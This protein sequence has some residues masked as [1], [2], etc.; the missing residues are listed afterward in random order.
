MLGRLKSW[1]MDGLF[2]F[3]GGVDEPFYTPLNAL[4]NVY[5]RLKNPERIQHLGDLHP[6]KIFYIIRDVPACTGLASWYD[7]VLGYML[8]AKRKGWV[9]VVD[10]PAPAK[11]DDG[12][13]YDFFKGPSDIPVEEALQ[14]SNVVFATEQAMVYKRFSKSN[15]ARRHL[16]A[17]AIQF[18]EEA[19]AFVDAHVSE[20]F[21]AMPRPT[22]G[23]VFRGTDYRSTADYRPT[24]HAKVPSLDFFCDEVLS[25]LKRWGVPEDGGANL[26]VVTE[27]QEAL[28]IIK[29]RFPKCNYAVKER[30]SN[31]DITKGNLFRQSLKTVDSKTNNLLYLTDIEALSDCDY[32]IG[33][34]VGAVLMALNLNGGR[35]SGVNILKTGVS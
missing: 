19:R 21:S 15:I 28:E 11:K 4:A 17:R 23:V 35:Y 3:L 25:S 32:L 20:I 29:K 14:G 24:G 8:R 6:D 30:F 16:I 1:F 18:S 22:V 10:P 13:W 31:F 2:H 5:L 34:M 33:G 27:E 12:G 9:P 26:F 7:R